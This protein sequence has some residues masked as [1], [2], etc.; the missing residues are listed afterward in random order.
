ME[1]TKGD[2]KVFLEKG[3][4]KIE[5]SVEKLVGKGGPRICFKHGVPNKNKAALFLRV[6]HFDQ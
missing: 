4:E 6:T 3:D 2:A 5:V 1:E